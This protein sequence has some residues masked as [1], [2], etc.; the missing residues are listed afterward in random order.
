MVLAGQLVRVN[1]TFSNWVQFTP[2]FTNFTVGAGGTISGKWRTAGGATIQWRAYFQ[3]GSGS[4]VAGQL[5]ITIPNGYTG[6]DGFQTLKV[7]AFD[8][9]ASSGYSGH[10]KLNGGGGTTYPAFYGPSGTVWNATTPF[11]WASGD[12]LIVSGETETSS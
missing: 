2:S 10:A 8:S 4:S 6:V 1:D 9:S 12:Y 5:G 3:F 7:F 11:T